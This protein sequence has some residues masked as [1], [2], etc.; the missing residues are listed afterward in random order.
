MSVK[1]DTFDALLTLLGKAETRATNAG[2]SA[3]IKR[4]VLLAVAQWYLKNN[5]VDNGAGDV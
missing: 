2:V 5:E 4:A 1:K 3:D